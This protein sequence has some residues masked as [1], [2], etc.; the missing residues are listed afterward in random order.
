VLA[1]ETEVAILKRVLRPEEGDMSPQAASEILKMGF[2]E[3]DHARMAVLSS[4]AQDGSLTA[5]EQEELDSYINVSH[6]IALM[7]SKARV[8][9]RGRGPNSSA[10]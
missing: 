6:L 10:A 4:K 3:P 2:N 7:H 9:L 1:T 8:A 5:S